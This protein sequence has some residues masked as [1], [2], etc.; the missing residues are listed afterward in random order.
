VVGCRVLLNKL[1]VSDEYVFSEENTNSLDVSVLNDNGVFAVVYRSVTD[2]DDYGQKIYLDIANVFAVS[3]SGRNAIIQ[4]NHIIADD[5]EIQEVGIYVS[6]DENLVVNN[7]ID[8]LSGSD[9]NIKVGV[10]ITSDSVRSVLSANKISNNLN[11]GLVVYGTNTQ[12]N[13]TMCFNNG[14]DTGIA[15][16]NEHNYLDEGTGTALG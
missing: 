1:Y 9:R 10:L 4:A 11:Y 3:S 13:N 16:E 15:N 6:G 12:I 8:G 7:Q 5:T 14:D 2:D